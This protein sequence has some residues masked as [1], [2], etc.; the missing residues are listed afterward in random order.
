MPRITPNEE[1]IKKNYDST[2][3]LIATVFKDSYPE[4]KSELY[5][6]I[7]RLGERYALCPASA[8]KEHYSAFPGGLAYHNLQVA[9]ELK[10]LVHLVVFKLDMV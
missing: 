5:Q 7:C 3:S 4:G 2:L 1:F 6:T 10:K 9:K 8:K